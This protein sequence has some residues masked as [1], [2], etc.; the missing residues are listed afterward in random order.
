MAP[1]ARARA[2]PR[3]AALLLVLLLVAAPLRP[4]RAAPQRFALVGDFGVN[5]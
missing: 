4:A 2:P 1:A 5:K 3:S